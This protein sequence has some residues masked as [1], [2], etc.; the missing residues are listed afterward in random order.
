MKIF[1]EIVCSKTK[2]FLFFPNHSVKKI[3]NVKL[4]AE[5]A[6]GSQDFRMITGGWSSFWLYVFHFLEW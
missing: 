5:S 6:D 1:V 4:Q 2:D 3:E